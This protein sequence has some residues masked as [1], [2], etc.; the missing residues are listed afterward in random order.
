MNDEATPY[1]EDIIDQMTVGHKYLLDNFNVIP[2]IGWQV[3]PFG[4]SSTQALF[5]HLMGFDGWFMGRID[6]EDK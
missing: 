4:H 2:H 1:Y 6:E 3:D 5:T